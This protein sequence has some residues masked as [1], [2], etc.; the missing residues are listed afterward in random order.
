MNRKQRRK[1]QS[2]ARRSGNKD[3]EEKMKLFSK[4]SDKCRV[5]QTQFDKLNS[6]MLS[7]WMIVV[8]SDEKTNL[9]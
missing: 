6:E 2:E 1:L 7:S 4:L 9:Y 3:L 8:R 5:C